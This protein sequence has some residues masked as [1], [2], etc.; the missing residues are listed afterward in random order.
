MLMANVSEDKLR[1]LM[2]VPVSLASSKSYID[3]SNRLRS[4]SLLLS[5][6]ERFVEMIFLDTPKNIPF[7]KQLT[8]TDALQRQLSD[9]VGVISHSERLT[10]LLLSLNSLRALRRFRGESFD[11]IDACHHF[12]ARQN[13]FLSQYQ[14]ASWIRIPPLPLPADFR[15]LAEKVKELSNDAS[16]MLLEEEAAG[17]ALEL[18]K[19]QPAP[20]HLRRV[21]GRWELAD[22][23]TITG[24]LDPLA[25]KRVL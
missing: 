7:R 13:K 6:Y 22:S 15:D 2:P 25:R 16:K 12:V 14:V 4:L 3:I 5:G 21:S 9:I 24:R 20:I 10:A 18:P 8:K 17:E 11:Y 1:R 23:Q 19:Q